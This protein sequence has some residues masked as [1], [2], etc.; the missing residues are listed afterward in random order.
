M[1]DIKCLFVQEH[2][3]ELAEWSAV[4]K[5]LGLDPQSHVLGIYNSALLG[6]FS[7][8]RLGGIYTQQNY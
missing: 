1:H 3:D 5:T 7:L 6:Q 2:A 8:T 4:I